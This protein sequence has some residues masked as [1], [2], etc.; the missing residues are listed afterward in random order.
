[1]LDITELG[2]L[3]HPLSVAIKN[4]LRIR[5]QAGYQGFNH[6]LS[7]IPYSYPG[8]EA[9]LKH[10][11]RRN[12]II[13][14]VLVRGFQICRPQVGIDFFKNPHQVDHSKVLM[15]D[16]VNNVLILRALCK[17]SKSSSTVRNMSERPPLPA[18]S[19]DFYLVVRRAHEGKNIDDQV[20]P[21]S[22]RVAEK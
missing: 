11:P 7:A 15:R 2:E 22:R 10:P 5:D 4:R 6:P 21:H 20:E 3:L 1:M 19:E 13:P 17:V 18:I 12:V 9:R 14:Y 8:L 16:V